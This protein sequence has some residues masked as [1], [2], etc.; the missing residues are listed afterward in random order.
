MCKKLVHMKHPLYLL[1]VLLDLH[2][3]CLCS[4]EGVDKEGKGGFDVEEKQHNAVRDNSN[5]FQNEWHCWVDTHKDK[6]SSVQ[7]FIPNNVFHA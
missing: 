5:I 4:W 1:Q 2:V 3:P 6:W 7:Y